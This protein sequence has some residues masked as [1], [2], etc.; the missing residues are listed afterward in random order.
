MA[1]LN[2]SLAHTV[3]VAYRQEFLKPLD[4]EGLRAHQAATGEAPT[5]WLA[6]MIDR[7]GT[8]R[9]VLCGI[10]GNRHSLRYEPGMSLA[11]RFGPQFDFIQRSGCAPG[12]CS[13]W[14][15]DPFQ[16]DEASPLLLKILRDSLPAAGWHP[17]QIWLN[18][19]GYSD[20]G[21]PPD[22]STS[23]RVFGRVRVPALSFIGSAQFES[24]VSM[25]LPHDS[26]AWRALLG[27]IAKQLGL[28]LQVA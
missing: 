27:S 2:I 15:P 17:N 10:A 28:K 26:V 22:P 24:G 6:L 12:M 25:L 11:A 20:R 14:L 8:P 16:L 5:W 21:E 1:R 13:V 4:A 19:R 9:E 18:T 23:L 3:P 7:D